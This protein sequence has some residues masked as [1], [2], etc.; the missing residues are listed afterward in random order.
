MARKPE[1]AARIFECMFLWCDNLQGT[2]I[3]EEI[4]K[5][6]RK[7]VRWAMTL[8]LTF[9]TAASIMIYILSAHKP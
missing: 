4:M 1:T 3:G 2:D 6:V 5:A 8:Q 7:G 9:L